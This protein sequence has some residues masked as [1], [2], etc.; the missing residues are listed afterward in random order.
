MRSS[1][2]RLGG[3]VWQAPSGH[4]APDIIYIMR[5]A[6]SGS[7]CVDVSPIRWLRLAI[8]GPMARLLLP[9]SFPQQGRDRSMIGMD[10]HDRIDKTGPWA[11]FGFQGRHMFT[12]RSP[13]RTLRHGLVVADLRHRPGMAVDDGGSSAADA[14]IGSS[15]KATSCKGFQRHLPA[16]RLEETQRKAVGRG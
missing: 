4:F 2:L 14:P 6:V 13:A 10:L 3:E 1:W 9:Y 5:N 11:G 7:L 8:A 12:R 16:R 15:P